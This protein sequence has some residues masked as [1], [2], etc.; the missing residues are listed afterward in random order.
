MH[1]HEVYARKVIRGNLGD[2]TL[3]TFADVSTIEANS[4]FID[5]KRNSRRRSSS[6]AFNYQSWR[7]WQKISHC[8]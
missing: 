7:K 5:K 2:L 4:T 1:V 6:A 3:K 8:V